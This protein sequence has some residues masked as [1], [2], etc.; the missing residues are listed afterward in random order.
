MAFKIGQVVKLQSPPDAL[1]LDTRRVTSRGYC[2]L[3]VISPWGVIVESP[4]DATCSRVLL[5]K[6]NNGG[7]QKSWPNPKPWCSLW[8]PNHVFYLNNE[9]PTEYF[10]TDFQPTD[11]WSVARPLK[12]TKKIVPL[13]PLSPPGSKWVPFDWWSL[14]KP[15]TYEIVLDSEPVLNNH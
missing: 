7:W 2:R 3:W 12:Y 14:A 4:K 13:G 9:Y 15:V 5:Y 8:L 1:G 10:S 11:W 6:E